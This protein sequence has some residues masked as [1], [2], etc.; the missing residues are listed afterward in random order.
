MH[1][2]GVPQRVDLHANAAS[3]LQLNAPACHPFCT[4]GGVLLGL[5]CRLI[6]FCI[7]QSKGA[8]RNSWLKPEA[9][10]R[11]D[12]VRLRVQ[13]GAAVGEGR[14][15]R[16]GA[17]AAAAVAA[18]ALRARGSRAAAVRGGRPALARR[19]ARLRRRPEAHAARCAHPCCKAHHIIAW[20]S[21]FEPRLGACLS[22]SSYNGVQLLATTELA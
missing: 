21:V 3:D 9:G 22:S 8:D 20:R 11:A 19:L 5:H 4:L 18:A 10:D 2:P 6:H 16:R 1:R 14:R 12:P 7:G 15:A 13:A 17:A